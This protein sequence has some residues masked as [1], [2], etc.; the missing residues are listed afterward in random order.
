V[1]QSAAVEQVEGAALKLLESLDRNF[2]GVTM[3]EPPAEP[4]AETKHR[5]ARRYAA[6]VRRLREAGVE[7]A[8]ET[9]GAEQYVALRA[10]WDRYIRALAPAMAYHPHEIDPA[11][12]DPDPAHHRPLVAA[13]AA[14]HEF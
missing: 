1:Q 11:G 5:W 6:A 2:L 7:T 9:A 14:S 12:A 8:Q 3:P 10:R 13:R 4:D